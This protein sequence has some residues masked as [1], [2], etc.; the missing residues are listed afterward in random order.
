VVPTASLGAALAYFTGSKAHN[1]A[2]RRLA[3]ERGL[4]INEY[5]VFRGTK[6]I[7]GDSEE[8]VYRAVGLPWIAPELREN[9]GEI[10][11]AQ[12]GKLPALVER[13]DLAGDLHVHTDETDGH[14]S[15]QAMVAAAKQQGL[16]Y[17]AITEH[18]RRQTMTHGL[19]AARLARQGVAIDRLNARLRGM[20]V[21]KGI[22]VDI[23]E[24]G[25]LDLP[26]DALAPLDVVVAA[27]HG[28]FGLARARQTA[29][30]LAALDNPHVRVL[31]HP[32]GRL[33][34]AREPYD[35]DMPA[36]VRKARE[37]GVAL[38]L[39]AHPERLDLNDTHCRLCKDEGVPVAINSD[40]HAAGDFAFLGLGIGQARRGWLTRDDV[41]NTRTLRALQEFLGH[42]ASG[43][44]R[45]RGKRR[46]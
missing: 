41:L 25:A 6:R 33:I 30:I 20:R 2:L 44:R 8:S 46:S 13:S 12:R 7:A 38:E 39:N 31:A 36:I 45:T 10:E 14:D 27:V 3:Q 26:D 22:E 23:L 9:R 34:G 17:I 21:L 16:A 1:I 40:A 15:L 42:T 28:H 32:T 19:D 37:R 5:G 18:S 11:A 4:K 35:V 24:D 29:R 43:R